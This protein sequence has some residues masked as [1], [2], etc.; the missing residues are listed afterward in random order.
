MHVGVLACKAKRTVAALRESKQDWAADKLDE[1]IVVWTS[2]CELGP[3]FLHKLTPA[4]LKKHSEVI[5]GAGH[6][7]TFAI[8]LRLFVVCSSEKMEVGQFDN[9]VA[10]L[11]PW[12]LPGDPLKPSLQA[13][14]FSSILSFC[15]SDYDRLAASRAMSDAFFSDPLSRMLKNPDPTELQA[16]CQS[17]LRA[18]DAISGNSEI[19]ESIPEELV[20]PLDNMM[21][22]ARALLA[23][24]LPRPTATGYDDVTA[25]F[26]P[27]KAPINKHLDSLR[28]AAKQSRFWANLI[29]EFWAGAV[30]DAA[31]AEGFDAARATVRK[32]DVTA[33]DLEQVAHK[34][35]EMKKN[36]AR[37]RPT[38]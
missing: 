29:D 17:L 32:H 27:A 7:L 38:S 37:A 33:E 21:Q 4:S 24:S 13:P 18:F 25:L 19:V 3:R 31:C 36:C 28:A 26:N 8:W 5:L 14:A 35:V 34:V 2:A 30:N 23:L 22:S 15:V 16:C 1:N 10:M 6:D 11:R 12:K 20:D 9:F